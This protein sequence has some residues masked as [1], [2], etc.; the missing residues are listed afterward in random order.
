MSK[1]I[2]LLLIL[3]TLLL[4]GGCSGDKIAF[5]YP[6]EQLDFQLR[7]LRTPSVFLETVTDMRSPEQKL[8]GGHFLGIDFPKDESWERPVAEV[9]A[10]AL[11]K[12]VE[13]TNL[14]QL[15]PLRGQ[16]DYVLSADIMSMGCRFER[17]A[18]SFLIPA[19]LGGALGFALGED[20]S[21]QAK[22]GVALAAV[23]VVAVPMPSRNRA[24]ADIRLTLKDRTGNILW[25]EACL[26]E[27]EDKV[28][29][30]A[31]SREDQ[32]YVDEH[33]TRAVKRANG[34]L[35]GQMRQFLIEEGGGEATNP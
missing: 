1:R 20:G 4:L 9:Y 13:Q 2:P 21:D 22:L 17:R 16:A 33:L 6:D 14:V 29:T 11:A 30:T 7:N 32:K 26:G 24:E 15:V 18:T 35:L 27:Y 34:C 5:N 8:G 3:P 25:Q 12:D 28:Y 19:V 31:T 10:E 23:G